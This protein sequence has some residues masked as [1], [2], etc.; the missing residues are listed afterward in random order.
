MAKIFTYSKGVKDTHVT[1]KVINDER[2]ISKIDE[3]IQNLTK[4]SGVR[5]DNLSNIGLRTNPKN[6]IRNA[7]KNFP[8]NIDNEEM[9]SLLFDFTEP[10]QTRMREDFKYAL[11]IV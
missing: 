9:K 11:I 3:I 4:I 5:E 2:D 10:M 6:W 8:T 1:D 7:I